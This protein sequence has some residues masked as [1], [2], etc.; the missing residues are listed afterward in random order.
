MDGH[1]EGQLILQLDVDEGVQPV[2]EVVRADIPQLDGESVGKE[3]EEVIKLV[4]KFDHEKAR[5]NK[6]TLWREMRKTMASDVVKDIF[7]NHKEDKRSEYGK[8][9][10]VFVT[11]LTIVKGREK[12]VQWPRTVNGFLDVTLLGEL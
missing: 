5:G 8:K 11:T 4:F 7:V 6:E 2:D 9:F 12:H 1:L 10:N 3:A